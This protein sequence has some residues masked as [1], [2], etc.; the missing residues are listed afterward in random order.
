V[1]AFGRGYKF[2]RKYVDMSNNGDCAAKEIYAL[3]IMN[4]YTL[5]V[6]RMV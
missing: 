2:G 6:V 4:K 1:G 5:S 3:N